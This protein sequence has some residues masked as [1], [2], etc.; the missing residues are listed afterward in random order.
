MFHY[1]AI[2]Y[3]QEVG[4]TRSPATQPRCPACGRPITD[5]DGVTIAGVRLH[6]S[7]ALRR[8]RAAKG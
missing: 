1:Q 2:G 6:L 5:A 7:C 4:L 3:L 8:R